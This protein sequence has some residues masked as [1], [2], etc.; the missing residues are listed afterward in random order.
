MQKQS[1]MDFMKKCFF[2]IT[3]VISIVSLFCFGSVYAN[4]I[5][6]DTGD[7]AGANDSNAPQISSD[8]NGRVYVTWN[9]RRNYAPD[10]YDDDVIDIYINH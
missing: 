6:L 4:D 5:R 8:E 3:F 1:K 9:D 7:T 2:N 10:I